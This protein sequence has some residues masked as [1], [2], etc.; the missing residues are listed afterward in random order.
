MSKTQVKNERKIAH[1]KMLLDLY[2]E[3]TE[4]NPAKLF[5]LLRVMETRAN[6][7]AVDRCNGIPQS[8]T[9]EEEDAKVSGILLKVRNLLGKTGP[10]IFFNTDCRGYS[11]KIDPEEMERFNV[12][13]DFHRDWGGHG[14]IA[15]DFD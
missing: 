15:P 6:N 14:I 7:F 4:K 5:R 10:A 12:T 8:M 11:L 2:P 3:A 1:G 13:R 9:E